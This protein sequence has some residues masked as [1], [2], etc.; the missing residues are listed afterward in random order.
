MK[1][2]EDLKAFCLNKKQMN[3]VNGGHSDCDKLVIKANIEG[4]KWNDKQWE[5]WTNAFMDC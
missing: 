3:E 5:E 1:T 4:H 2:L